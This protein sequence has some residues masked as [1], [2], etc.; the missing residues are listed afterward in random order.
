MLDLVPYFRLNGSSRKHA[1]GGN[2][3]FARMLHLMRVVRLVAL[4][5]VHHH[6]TT[7]CPF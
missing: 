5:D 2:S 4:A 7:L 1:S 6:E 3:G